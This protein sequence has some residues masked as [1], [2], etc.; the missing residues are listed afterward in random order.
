LIA[1]LALPFVALAQAESTMFRHDPAHIGVYDSQPPTLKTVKWRFDTHAKI[2]SSPAVVHNVVYVGSFDGKL[3]AV[4]AQ[5]GAPV[6]SFRTD[7]PVNSSPAVDENTV[8]FSSLDG[9]VYAVDASTGNER[10]RFKTKG[11]RRFTAPGIHGITP[12]TQLM[13]DPYDVLLSSPNVSDGTV[14]VGSGD[15]HV[16]A[17]DAATGKVRWAFQTGNVVHASP[18]VYHDTVYIGSWDRYFYALDAHTGAVRW[19]FATG[20]DHDIYNQ[21]GIQGSAAVANGSVYF[22]ARD[23]TFYALDAQTGALRWKHD[24]HGSWVIGSPALANGNVYYTT[25]DEQKFWALNAASGAERFS[26]PYS[27]F[28][29]SSPSIAGN[30]AFFGAFDGRLYGVNLDSG[31]ATEVFATDGARKN[32]HLN[33]KGLLD[34]QPFYASNTLQGVTA[35]LERVYALGSIV[36]SPAIVDGTLYVG[37]ADGNLYAI[38]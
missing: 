35:G 9:N 3:Y 14:F 11:E 15:H 21:V 23:S 7:G 13:A 37:S 32:L 19:K 12:K 8:Y 34:L 2:L 6:W 1:F 16:Y 24:E 36:G 33:A 10:W 29:F 28:S 38:G 18:A 30:M 5:T 4:N 17:L 20:D 31:K 22:G 26:V 27:T 25:S